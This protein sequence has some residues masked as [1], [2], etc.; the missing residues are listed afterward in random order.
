MNLYLGADPQ[1]HLIFSFNKIAKTLYLIQKDSEYKRQEFTESFNINF[2]N[3]NNNVDDKFNF[4]AI[5][6]G[7]LTTLP[8]EEWAQMRLHLKNLS[9]TNQQ[10]LHDIESAL[11]TVCLD[12]VSSLNIAS[13][14]NKVDYCD[15]THTIKSYLCENPMNRWFD[16]STQIIVN[17]LK[18]AAILNN[19]ACCDISGTSR[20]ISEVSLLEKHSPRYYE[21]SIPISTQILDQISK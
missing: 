19:I 20:L 9:Q 12:E 13:N 6:L 16:K 8:R 1:N 18:N 21:A 5:G 11:F 10:N 2:K 4:D 14:E 3:S 17:N 7:A 15:K